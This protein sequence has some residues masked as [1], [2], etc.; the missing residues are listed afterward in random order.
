MEKKYIIALCVISFLLVNGV[1]YFDEG[2]RNFNYLAEPG[3][4]V[5]ILMFTGLGVVL[6]L[7]LFVMLK[8]KIKT[9]FYR[10]LIGFSPVVLLIVH[11]LVLNANY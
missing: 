3:E 9:R 2:T 8:K 1:G 4:W 7:T 6:P 5:I 11:L 10:S